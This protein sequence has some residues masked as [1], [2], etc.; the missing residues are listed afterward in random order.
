MGDDNLAAKVGGF[1]ADAGVDT[2]ADN[3]INNVIDA[4]ASHVPGGS[5]IDGFLK[6][7]VDLAANNEINAEL[8]KFGIGQ[9]SAAPAQVAQAPQAPE[10]PPKS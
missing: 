10:P 2:F 6:T 9:P 1:A 3:G 5:M 8:G 4:V 7:G